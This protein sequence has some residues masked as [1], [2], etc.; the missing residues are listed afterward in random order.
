MSGIDYRLLVGRKNNGKNTQTAGTI[1]TSVIRPDPSG[2]GKSV[3]TALSYLPGSTAHTLTVM[4]P[5]GSTLVT[6]AAAASQADIVLDSI[7]LAK[8]Y[9]GV[10]LAE[11][12]A[13]NDFIVVKHTD[14][15]YGV[16]KIS[17]I[18]TLTLTLTANL[19]K[20]V[21]ADSQV[22]GLYEVGRTLGIEHTIFPTV[23]STLFAPA[24]DPSVGLAESFK[25]GEPLVLHSDNAT[26]AGVLNYLSAAY[27][28]V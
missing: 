14:G 25:V 13:A 2:R 12:L 21:A 8:D 26:A 3:I 16:Y 9:L 19:A 1:I 18:A 11:N 4:R 27:L 24:V 7:S 6:S 23:A 10:S 15:T 5:Q 17:S 28:K 20:A 22:W